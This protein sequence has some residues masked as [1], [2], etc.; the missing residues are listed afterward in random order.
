MDEDLDAYLDM[1]QEM[2]DEFVPDDID[3]EDMEEEDQKGKSDGNNNGASMMNT[4]GEGK[5]GANTV[6]TAKKGADLDSI[7]YQKSSIFIGTGATQT[8][9]SGALGGG[10]AKLLPSDI[11]K[12]L[13]QQKAQKAA[14]N[15]QDNGASMDA[16]ALHTKLSVTPFLTQVSIGLRL[17]GIFLYVDHV[18]ATV[19]WRITK[20]RPCTTIHPILFI[21]TTSIILIKTILFYI[22]HILYVCSK[23]ASLPSLLRLPP[24]SCTADHSLAL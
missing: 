16:S 11:A 20:H 3:Y 10:K 4:E 18:C 15:G 13:Q 7:S 19:D 9:M 2:E 6:V 14:L 21:H 24:R 17:K 12:S 8:G 5:I 1:E 22:I 23:R